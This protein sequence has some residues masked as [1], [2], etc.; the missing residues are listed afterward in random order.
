MIT[1][2]HRIVISV[3][4]QVCNLIVEKYGLTERTAMT[5]F[6]ESDTYQ[7]LI[8]VVQGDFLK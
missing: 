8:D 1:D 2:F 3:D 7:M 5:D 6:F 4:R